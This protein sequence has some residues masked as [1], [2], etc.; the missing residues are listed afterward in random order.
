MLHAA[1]R[2]VGP[3]SE[4]LDVDIAAVMNS[5]SD[6]PPSSAAPATVAPT[7][8]PAAPRRSFAARPTRGQV[9][10]PAAAATLGPLT[11]ADEPEAR[12]ALSAG[13]VASGPAL[14]TPEPAA[15]AN[16]S[17]AP[18]TAFGEG[19]V[20]AP[21]RL[22]ATSPLLY[23]PAARSA[24]LETD[25]ALEIVVDATGRVV[26]ARMLSR[27]GYGLDEAALRA[28]RDYRFSP[29]LRGGRAVPVRMR[30]TMQ[31]RLR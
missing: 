12:F 16:A 5:P 23:P 1:A 13:T 15:S 3:E 8:T 11:P 27:A 7:R 2:S 19:D 10:A 17:S 9:S 26:S 24:V 21:A 28:I 20:D 6:A 30:W 4:V 31:F 25:V 22:R 14:A 18:P 29:A